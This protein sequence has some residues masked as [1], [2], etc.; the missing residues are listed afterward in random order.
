MLD[1][2]PR[3]RSRRRRRPR[4]AQ[5]RGDRHRWARLLT[6][7]VRGG[8]PGK[9]P[10]RTPVQTLPDALGRDDP[11]ARTRAGDVF[12]DARAGL[13]EWLPPYPDDLT[14]HLPRQFQVDDE[15]SR[16]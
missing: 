15:G 3:T 7:S 6:L 5:H 9:P 2:A 14:E 1:D 11:T 16:P 12:D 8:V 4:P 10:P 13:Q